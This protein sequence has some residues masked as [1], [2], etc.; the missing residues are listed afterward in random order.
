[1]FYRARRQLAFNT[2]HLV[3]QKIQPAVDMRNI[4]LLCADMLAQNVH[5]FVHFR[6]E[7]VKFFVQPAI[8]IAQIGEDLID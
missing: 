4:H 5:F 7:M 1:M 6:A 8:I 2:L 3:A